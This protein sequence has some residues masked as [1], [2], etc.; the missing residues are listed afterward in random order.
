MNHLFGWANALAFQAGGESVRWSDLLGNLLGLATVALAIRRSLWA[1]P[2]QIT[3]AVLLFG[4]SMSVHLGGN[5]A[6]QLVVIAAASY[7]WW[8]W[9]RQRG[10]GHPEGV[11]IRWAAPLERL[12]LLGFLLVGTAGFAW[13]LSATHASWA[14]LPDAYIFVGSLAATLCQGRGWVEFW[15][16]WIAVDVV[17]VPLAFHSGLPVSGFTYGVYFLLVLAGMR[18]WIRLAR[19]AASAAAPRRAPATAVTA[20]ASVTSAAPATRA[21]DVVTEGVCA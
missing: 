2:V 12:A 18:Q 8:R 15:F 7:G 1:W 17:G 9:N 11:S 14:P 10:A 21:V 19:P 20:P 3:G 13:L 6:R 5:A 4:A 16:V